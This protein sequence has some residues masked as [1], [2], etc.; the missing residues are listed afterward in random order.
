MP[1]I[2]KN[3]SGL[4]I[5]STKAVFDDGGKR[6][7]KMMEELKNEDNRLAAVISR[8]QSKVNGM[9][10]VSIIDV[11]WQKLYNMQ[12][13]AQLVAGQL[14]RITDYECTSTQY[15]VQTTQ[16]L[17]Y[18]I[19]LATSNNT[20][21]EQAM[22]QRPKNDTYFQHCNLDA[23]KIE[24][25][26]Y[27]EYYDRQKKSGVYRG[28]ITHMIDEHGNECFYDFKNVKFRVYKATSG[29]KHIYYPKGGRLPQGYA[30]NTADLCYTFNNETSG[31]DSVYAYCVS[32]NNKIGK[33]YISGHVVENLIVLIRS[34]NNVFGNDCF[35]NVLNI[36]CHDNTF[37]N[38]CNYNS[39]GNYCSSNTF[40]YGCT[41]NTF[42][43]ECRDNTFGSKCE[44]NTFDM[45]CYNNTFGNRCCENSF[46]NGCEN[47]SL[48]NISNMT[49][50]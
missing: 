49:F 47:N 44:N 28:T 37:G 3:K 39:F 43:N 34:Y 8:L 9:S 2:V 13:N 27:D 48:E 26:L 50:N 35:N 21:S 32:K 17:F 40:G 18:I 25:R 29:N 24:Y 10:A 16:H 46:A 20:L 14:Y 15:D 12:C 19:V 38:Y 1:K 5:T 31:D 7:D 6:L 45:Q 23:W 33:R 36:D 4:P 42:G 22:A 41:F 30:Y 11:T